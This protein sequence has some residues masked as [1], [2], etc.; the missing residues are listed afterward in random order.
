MSKSLPL[1]GI[2]VECLPWQDSSTE[3]QVSIDPEKSLWHLEIEKLNKSSPMST[4]GKSSRRYT[5]THLKWMAMRRYISDAK[6]SG[7]VL[8]QTFTWSES[9]VVRALDSHPRGH[10]FQSRSFRCDE[11]KALIYWR[12]D[13]SRVLFGE[14]FANMFSNWWKR[15]RKERKWTSSG[16]SASE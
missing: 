3:T 12:L 5:A 4:L 10:G 13:L 6:L 8:P 11:W 14:Y 15:L 1:R 9:W 2:V 7:W 16:N